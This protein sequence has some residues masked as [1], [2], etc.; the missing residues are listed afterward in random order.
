[1]E[2]EI[3]ISLITSLTI[4]FIFLLHRHYEYKTK[5]IE[6]EIIKESNPNSSHITDDEITKELRLSL[7]NLD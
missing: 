5:V 1:M 7:Q 2:K 4:L 6:L 3:V